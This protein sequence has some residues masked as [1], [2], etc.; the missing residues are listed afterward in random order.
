MIASEVDP[1]REDALPAE[2]ASSK[3]DPMGKDNV[4]PRG[5]LEASQAD[6]IIEGFD[7]P[8]KLPLAQHFSI[9][10][11]LDDPHE[12]MSKPDI[13]PMHRAPAEN[14]EPF[15]PHSKAC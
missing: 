8:T 3:E 2:E 14:A 9:P 4:A 5:T 10:N 7:R 6:L 15:F 11:G 1:L 13:A 12:L